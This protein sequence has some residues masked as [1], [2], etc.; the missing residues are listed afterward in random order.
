ME[1]S[2]STGSTDSAATGATARRMDAIYRYQRHVYDATR[3][4]Y[5]I[6]RD[7]LIDDLDPPPGGHVLELGCGTGRN[8]V[9]A[10]LR[11]PTTSLVGV[12]ISGEML[13]SAERAVTA[14][15]VGE[16][17]RLVR[18]DAATV[19]LDGA[20][21]AGQFDRVYFSYAL[22]MIPDWHG[23]LDHALA[24][25]APSGRL[26]IVDFGRQEDLPGPVAAAVFAWLRFNCVTPRADLETCLRAQAA[27]R[28]GCRLDYRSLARGYAHCAVLG[29]SDP[30]E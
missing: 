6:G 14:A 23:A 22:S 18:G 29:P 8:L 2:I 7:R 25:L 12:D 1:A 26:H 9:S 17:V 3:K 13:K 30:A 27:R 24:R 16:R 28:D 10:A 5:L 11:Y 4:Y 20:G 15:G 19:A 21:R